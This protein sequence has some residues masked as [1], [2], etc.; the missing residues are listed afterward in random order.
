VEYNADG[1]EAEPAQT[2]HYD[3]KE[4]RAQTSLRSENNEVL[5]AAEREMEMF[6]AV[7]CR[8]GS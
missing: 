1:Q 5:W 2:G 3:I 7:S 8:L 4:W 6:E